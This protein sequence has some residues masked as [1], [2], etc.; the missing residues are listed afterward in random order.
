MLTEETYP[1]SSQRV[2]REIVSDKSF[3][4]E[5]GQSSHPFSGFNKLSA[6]D[7]LK[8]LAIYYYFLSQLN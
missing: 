3:M 2:L 5:P 8:K 6:E 7:Y 1:K 4:F